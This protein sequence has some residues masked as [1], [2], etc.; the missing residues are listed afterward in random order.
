MVTAGTLHDNAGLAIQ[1]PDKPLKGLKIGGEVWNIE[2]FYNNFS[3]GTEDC[4]RAFPLGNI[5]TYC[6]NAN[7]KVS[8]F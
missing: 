6:I 4:Y 1:F 5:D 8:H 2:R 7:L 3:A